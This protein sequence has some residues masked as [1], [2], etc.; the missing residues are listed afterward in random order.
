MQC[1]FRA[2]GRRHS[3]LTETHRFH[4]DVDRPKLYSVLALIAFFAAMCLIVGVQRLP[5]ADAWMLVILGAGVGFIGFR[6]WRFATGP[7]LEIDET[8]IRVAQ[9]FEFKQ[10]PY[11]RIRAIAKYSGTIRPRT[12]RGDGRFRS[13]SKRLTIH[14]LALRLADGALVSIVLPSFTDNADVL[15]L[16]ERSSGPPIERFDGDLP[17]AWRFGTTAADKQENHYE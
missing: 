2:R 3:T 5:D 16:L 8:G 14:R 15:D 11:S 12:F 7:T 17:A 1:K 10:Y 13:S 6:L 9:F 4:Q